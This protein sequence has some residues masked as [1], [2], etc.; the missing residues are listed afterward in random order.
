MKLRYV[1]A[2][3]LLLVFGLIVIAYFL[4]APPIPESSFI[5]TSFSILDSGVAG[6]SGYVIFNYYGDGSISLLSYKEK[7]KKEITIIN[8]S[9]SISAKH[10]KDLFAEVKKLEEYGYTVSMSDKRV[11]GD[12][13]FIVPTGAFPKYVLDDLNTGATNA[14]V[15]FFGKD[16]L[17]LNNGMKNYEW[18]S[19]L[20]GSARSRLVFYNSTLDDYWDNGNISIKKELLE[21][22]WI[23]LNRTDR[24]LTGS[25]KSTGIVPISGSGYIRVVYSIGGLNGT[26]DSQVLSG[27]NVILIPEKQSV[28]PWE[29]GALQFTLSKTNGTAQF[30]AK[31][32]GDLQ[33]SENLGR[34]GEEPTAFLKNLEY[35]TPGTYLLEVRDNGGVV[36]SGV[37]HVKNVQITPIGSYGFSYMFNVTVDGVPLKSGEV[38]ASLNNGTQ[39]KKFY[40]SNG[41][42]TI[43]AN[44]QKGQNVFHI[45][46]L[47]GSFVNTVNF[48]NENMFDVYLKYGI[49]GLIL[50]V[51]VYFIAR[52]SRKPHYVLRFGDSV[53][54][55]RKDVG[56]KTSDAVYSFNRIKKDLNLQNEP[57]N[58]HEFGMALKKY[59][60]AG[61]DVTEGNVEHI[62]KQLVNKGILENHRRYYQLKGNGNITHTSKMRVVRDLLIAAGIPFKSVGN[63]FRTKDYDLGVYGMDCERKSIIVVDDEHELSDILSK[64]SEK[65]R[66]MVRLLKSNGLLEFVTLDKLGDRL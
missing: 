16:N 2:A 21:N 59:V 40:V 62:L 52:M 30:T 39:K 54:E 33:S 38:M 22:V 61:A 44:L 8:D 20:S 6:N 17:I 32:N 58:A 48:E 9:E 3:V 14:T 25:G 23:L 45:G 36:A 66:A 18:Y 51:L 55:I 65:E 19:N 7:P 29:K 24:N 4:A 56:F 57:I 11:L 37:Y 49:P 10:I 43:P 60:T 12:G 26:A 34:I 41:A 46:L 1:L 5:K 47:G 31:L 64:M 15:V 53:R 28:F 27:P 35:K 50:V 63:K 42:L 13:I